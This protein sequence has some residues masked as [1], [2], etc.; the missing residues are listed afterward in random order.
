VD[1][2]HLNEDSNKNIF[3]LYPHLF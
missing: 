1:D 3:L 2:D